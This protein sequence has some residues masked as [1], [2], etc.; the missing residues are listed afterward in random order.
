MRMPVLFIGH[1]A[2]TN[3]LANNSYT[4][5][6][7]KLGKELPSPKAILCVSAHWVT[8]ESRVLVSE[9]PKTIH[10]FGGFPRELYQVQYPA[11]GAAETARKISNDFSLLTDESWGLDHG[12]WSVLIHM[13]PKADVPV[14]QLSL[15]QSKN[16]EEHLEL[17]RKLESLRDQGI[18]I[19]GS[20][21]LTHN[22][23]EINWEPNAEPVDWAVE[24]DSKAQEALEKRDESFLTDPSAWGKGLFRKNHPTADHYIPL[25]YVLGASTEK[26][27]LSY[28][29]EGFEYG[30][31]SMRMVKFG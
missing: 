18:L 29:Y 15:D 12:T 13:Y 14:F 17:G 2:P 23:G 26:D 22:L 7:T 4:H 3:A 10:D 28:P 11:P 6:L 31:L 30:S 5:A 19:L 1:G 27:K 16:F 25:L 9:K 21:N 20:G 24:F 8:E